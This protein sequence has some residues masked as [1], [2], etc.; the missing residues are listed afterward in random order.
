[1]TPGARLL[2]GLCTLLL[3]GCGSPRVMQVNVPLLDLR[4]QPGSAPQP[5]VHDPHQE[6]Q[7]FYGETVEVKQ[8]QA[9][10]T[11]IEAKEQPE[12]SHHH[13]WQGYPGWVRESAL[14]RPAYV[15]SP[16]IVIRVPWAA[17]Y[18]DAHLRTPSS[19]PFALGT[20]LPAVDIGGVLWRVEL[21]DGTFV[22][23]PRASAL[24]LHQ[25]KQLSPGQRRE[26]IL[27]TA[28]QLVGTP[29]YWGGRAAPLA[30]L[31]HQP[32]GFD[33]SGLVN[34]AYR[35]AGIDIPRDAHEQ[36][37]KAQPVA[38]LQP[39]DLI[40]LSA[41]GEPQRIVHVMLYA[42]GNEVIE[43]PGTGLAVRHISLRERLGAAHT[44]LASGVVV[45][46]QTVTLGTYLQ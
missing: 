33:C 43:A 39:A 4:A 46:G 34:V 36:S 45:N 16:A 40:F 19:T 26:L 28:A 12:F 41:P 42:G 20:R 6:T 2:G 7:L 22:W 44:T 31:P 5:G 37:L 32:T 14:I 11:R 10:W 13:R 8:R 38:A 15:L 23:L 24:D 25:L 30:A 3:A 29:Y 21:A 9:D 27:A 17:S 1:M 35:V 18:Q